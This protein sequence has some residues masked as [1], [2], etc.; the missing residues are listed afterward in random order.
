MEDNQI[1]SVLGEIAEK[2]TYDINCPEREC[3]VL[4]KYE[5]LRKQAQSLNK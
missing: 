1:L 5:I 4:N 3:L 2:K